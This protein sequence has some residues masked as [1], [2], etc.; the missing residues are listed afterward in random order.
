[1]KR[2]KVFSLFS[3]AGGLDL[4]FRLA[5]EFESV[6]AN[7][8]LDA[9]TPTFSNN[10]KIKRTD[11]FQGIELP[12]VA[13]ANVKNLNFGSLKCSPDVVVGGPPC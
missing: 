2:L 13:W 10:F 4:G 12:A 7:D 5:N 3:G 8:V 9:P 6:F 1:L 11:V